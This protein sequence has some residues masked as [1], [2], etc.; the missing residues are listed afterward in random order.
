MK[1]TTAQTLFQAYNKTHLKTHWLQDDA[2]RSAKTHFWVLA[3]K[4]MS[5][6]QPSFG[7]LYRWSQSHPSALST[8]AFQIHPSFIDS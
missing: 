8:G 3:Y 4:N 7:K 5:S 2:T 1:I 6:L